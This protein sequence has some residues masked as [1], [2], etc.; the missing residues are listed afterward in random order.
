MSA[1]IL[2]FLIGVVAGLRAMTEPA[3]VS[4]VARLSWLPLEN[5]WLAFL[6]YSFTPYIL[7]FWQSA[8]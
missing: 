4:W 8:S 5:T 2:A 3:P 6:G 1:Y 7:A